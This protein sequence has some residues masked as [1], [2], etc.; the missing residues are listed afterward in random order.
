MRRALAK[1]VCGVGV[2]IIGAAALLV[3]TGAG[4]EYVPQR[5]HVSTMMGI[6][7]ASK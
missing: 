2:P 3:A 4:L 7:D 1:R 6:R 5:E